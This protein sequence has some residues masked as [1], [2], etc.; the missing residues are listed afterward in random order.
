MQRSKKY[1]ES[2]MMYHEQKANE[3]YNEIKVIEDKDRLIGFK[4]KNDDR[5]STDMV[6]IKAPILNRPYWDV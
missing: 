1:L 5:Q 6:S 3:Y 2:K 4:P